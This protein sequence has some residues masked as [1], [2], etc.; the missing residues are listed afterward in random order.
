MIYNNLS[1]F[2]NNNDQWLVTIHEENK[3][4]KVFIFCFFIGKFLKFEK[5]DRFKIGGLEKYFN[6]RTSMDTTF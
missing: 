5:E 6:K 4:V 2:D 3:K 1:K